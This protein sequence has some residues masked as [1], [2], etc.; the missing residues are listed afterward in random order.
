M[1]LINTIAAASI[2]IVAAATGAQAATLNGTFEVR[3]VNYTFDT[4][5]SSSVS[6]A[7]QSNFDARYAAGVDGET[8][9]TFTFSGAL[10]FFVPNPTDEDLESILQFLG[11]SAGGSITGLDATV[12][13]L[14][15]SQ[16]TFKTTTLFEF[17]EVYANAFET[18]VTHDDGFA[19][20]DDG[21][22][23]VSYSNPTGIR[24]TPGN[25]Q[26][27]SFTGGEFRLIYAAA[28]GNPSKLLVEGDGVPAVPLPASALLLMGGVGALGAMRR[29]KARS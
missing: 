24:T 4:N 22:H 26:T 7:N 6:V 23:L 14:R 17:T 21:A 1:K 29:R 25:N 20:Y 12:G 13:G 10:D 2:A 19:I 18:S 3:V 11:T 27:A 28:N 8:R 5:Q 9:D 15:L 16:P